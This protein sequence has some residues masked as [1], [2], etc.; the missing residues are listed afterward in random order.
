MLVIG[1]I[2]GNSSLIVTCEVLSVAQNAI[3]GTVDM[4]TPRMDFP[5]VTL[6]D[7]RILVIGGL[8]DQG[9]GLAQTEFHTR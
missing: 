3:L 7:G 6:N 8:D 2:D 9:A 4:A 1:G 5:A